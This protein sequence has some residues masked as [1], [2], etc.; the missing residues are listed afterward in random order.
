MTVKYEPISVEYVTHSGNDMLVVNAARQSFAKQ[1]NPNQ[2]LSQGDIGL[3]NYLARGMSSS[4][5]DQMINELV[6]NLSAHEVE[7]ALVQYR[8]TPTHWAPFAHPHITVRA[9]APVPIRTQCFKHKIGLTE[10]EESRRYITSTPSFY[11]PLIRE[12]A[13]N[14]KQGSAGTHPL[15]DY[16]QD[17][18][19]QHYERSVALY[20]EMLRGNVC[21]EQARM[22]LPQGMIVNWTWTGSLYAFANFYIQRSDSHAQ[23]EVRQVAE[24]IDEIIRPLFPHSWEALV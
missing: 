5:Y 4:D 23:E 17:V 10:S 24:Q 22:V 21:P 14:V 1:K 9:S 18:T 7:N 2:P 16:Y 11:M 3:L 20:E 13:E 8:K 15:N 12:S 6:G 19:G